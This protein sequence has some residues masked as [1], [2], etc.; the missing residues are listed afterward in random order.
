MA[1]RKVLVSMGTRPEA[2]KMAPVVRALRG[3]DWCD[4]RLLATAQHRAMLDQVL[5]TFDLRVDRDLDLMRNDQSLPDLTARMLGAVHDVLEQEKPDLALVQGD[6]TTVFATALACFYAGIP[7]GHVEAGL[8]T[9]DRSAP[10]PE[11]MNRAM[12]S[13]LASMHFAPTEG[14]ADNLRAEGVPAE[15]IIVTGNPVIDALLWMAER[16][17][18]SRFAAPP[19]QH[20]I[21]VTA[22]RRESFGEPLARICAALRT[23]ADRPD[24][25]IVYP[26]HPN[27]S[28]TA[29]VRELLGDHGSIA[30]EQPLDYPE[31]VA[32]M[33][34]SRLILTDSGGIQEEAP[35]LGVPVLVMRD[36]TE[37]PEAIDAGTARLVGTSTDAI[38]TRAQELL[39]DEAAHSTA[40]QRANPFGDGRAAARIVAAVEKLTAERAR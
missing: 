29:P 37:R 22:H 4:V 16:V 25:R 23:L 30:L 19:G 5:A 33:Q 12:V 31:F 15:S 17:P 7:C 20:L 3:T 11:E 10:F 6:T 24:V 14:A 40:A 34:A 1:R 32:A 13:R 9:H 8:R 26:V 18:P 39:D 2:I 27:P 35:S 38:I 28:V 21:L 36:K